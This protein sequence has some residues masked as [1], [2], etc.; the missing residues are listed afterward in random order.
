MKISKQAKVLAVLT[1]GTVE[2]QGGLF[3]APAGGLGPAA[4]VPARA[5]GEQLE[6]LSDQD[7]GE[8][9][10]DEHLRNGA[11]LAELDARWPGGWSLALVSTDQPRSVDDRYRAG[12][13]VGLALALR[14]W[15]RQTRPCVNVLEVKPPRVLT[16]N[17]ADASEEL[18]DQIEKALRS[19][20]EATQPDTLVLM[21]IGATPAMRV[22]TEH[23]AG[24]LHRGALLRLSPDP[25]N[26]P[27]KETS[28]LRVVETA[29]V[30]SELASQ[31][32]K[33]LTSARYRAAQLAATSLTNLGLVDHSQGQALAAWARVG[34][35]M[36]G[37]ERLWIN[38][39]ERALL[40]FDHCARIN[41]LRDIAPSPLR[42]R[43]E[44]RI[45]VVKRLEADGQLA[46]AASHWVVAAEMIPLLW[47]ASKGAGDRAIRELRA[48]CAGASSVRCL[49]PRVTDAVQ[50]LRRNASIID[51]AR[52][53]AVCG[54]LRCRACPLQGMTT[55]PGSVVG[56]DRDSAKLATQLRDVGPQRV[57]EFRNSFMHPREGGRPDFGAAVDREAASLETLRLQPERTLVGLVSVVFERLM[58]DAPNDPLDVL[59]T[60][61]AEL[62]NTT[63]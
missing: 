38:E 31:Y 48:T 58:G 59:E 53:A 36:A 62:M 26:G 15:I 54:V 1:V 4:K 46:E 49:Q 51:I 16:A 23:V 11:C 45:G 57:V 63:T 13:T 10:K 42:V 47:L 34:E 19:A 56:G 22:L 60:A 37:D 17:P 55:P 30:R 8:L 20:L 33:A 24:R 50:K 2:V 39:Q 3:T 27:V 28:L 29:R 52:S 41:A 32:A 44:A 35:R 43:V 7:L 25:N 5:Y 6:E 14:R 21:T 40:D 9:L 12:D 61:N 18:E